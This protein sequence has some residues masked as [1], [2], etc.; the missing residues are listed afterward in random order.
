MCGKHTYNSLL[1]LGLF[2]Q[3]SGHEKYIYTNYDKDFIRGIV[4]GDGY[5]RQDLTEIGIVG[6]YELLA[7]IQERFFHYLKVKP[8]KIMV[9]GT[10]FKSVIVVNK[11]SI[12][13]LNGYTKMRKFL[14]SGNKRLQ[15]IYS[16]KRYAKLGWITIR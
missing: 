13:L 7:T 1:Q 4:D 10:I 5:I 8:N 11:L 12:L 3:K 15:I 14:W 6:S 9:H 2:P 16:M